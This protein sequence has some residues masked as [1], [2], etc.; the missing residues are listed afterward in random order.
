MPRMRGGKRPCHIIDYPF[1]R[2]GGSLLESP[3]GCGA[4][5]GNVI[6]LF[7]LLLRRITTRR[8]KDKR[9]EYCGGVW[10]QLGR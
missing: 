3:V 6:D 2:S 8:D 9:D 4:V 1:A 10:H 5:D 7:N